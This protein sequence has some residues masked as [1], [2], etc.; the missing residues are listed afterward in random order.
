MYLLT[1][2]RDISVVQALPTVP[3]TTLSLETDYLALTVHAYYSVS[4]TRIAQFDLDLSVAGRLTPDELDSIT[5][6]VYTQVSTQIASLQSAGLL[7]TFQGDD[8]LRTGHNDMLEVPNLPPNTTKIIHR[9]EEDN[10]SLI[11][12]ELVNDDLSIKYEFGAINPNTGGGVITRQLG[13]EELRTYF[14]QHSGISFEQLLQW[15]STDF[16]CAHWVRVINLTE[17][18]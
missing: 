4:S 17:T 15:V 10:L 18:N 5:E 2:I 16:N 7:R 14:Y 3:G 9:L 8:S 13:S 12:L 6:G 11:S 1:N